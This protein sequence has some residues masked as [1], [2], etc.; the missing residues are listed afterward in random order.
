MAS[1]S[2]FH[3]LYQSFWGERWP[4]LFDALKHSGLQV[5]RVNLFS[6]GLQPDDAEAFKPGYARLKRRDLVPMGPPTRGPESLLDYYIMD[7]GSVFIAE[8]LDVRRGQRVLDMCAAPGG[9]SLV[10]IEALAA[11]DPADREL[12]S[13]ILL[14]EVS[15]SR[16]ER[17]TKVIQQY[18]P[19]AVRN[20]V[21]V[22]GKDGGKFA[23][24]HKDSF[25]RILV[26]APCSGEA[27]LLQ[28]PKT[29]ADWSPKWTRTL[30]Q[31]QYAL[32]TGALEALKPGGEMVFSTCSLSKTE[33]E[34]VVERLLKKKSGRLEKIQLDVTSMGGE[35][36]EGMG[37]FL[38]DHCVFGPLF[39]AK[40]RK[41]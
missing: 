23:L 25:D 7:P 33:N 22:T 34:A 19:R 30:A 38:P 21:F 12:D 15:A 5:A 32:L 10:L 29:L 11:G 35:N 20:S 1:Q 26:D 8:L 27:H 40:F 13:E 31:R 3:D 14:N 2:E 28:D 39:V 9:K 41:V 24:T 16:R 37:Y 17:L 18:V 6:S 36:H 4:A